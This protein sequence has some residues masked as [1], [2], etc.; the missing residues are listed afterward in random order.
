ML[1]PIESKIA[2]KPIGPYSQAMRM[3]HSLLFVSGQIAL[4]PEGNEPLPEGIEAQTEQVM[5]NLSSILHQAGT[6]FSRVVKT[7][8]FLQDMNDFPKVNEIYATFF[9]PPYPA[10]ETVA[11]AGLPKSALIEI[12][13]I[14]SI[15][16]KPLV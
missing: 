13:C 3:G 15:A 4:G 5:F 8:I 7:S 10:R 9:T 16:D 6:D 1:F 14:V 2:P 12:S 11:V